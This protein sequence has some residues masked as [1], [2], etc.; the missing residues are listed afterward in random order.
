M[1][2]VLSWS[3]FPEVLSLPLAALFW[4][5]T[6][7]GL[8]GRCVS[9]WAELAEKDDWILGHFTLGRGPQEK[10]DTNLVSK[11]WT[12]QNHCLLVSAR[13]LQWKKIGRIQSVLLYV[14][15][16]SQFML[17]LSWG[18]FH[19]ISTCY[20]ADRAALA[21]QCSIYQMVDIC[22]IKSTFL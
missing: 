17:F 3:E 11:D 20:L 8:T 1:G 16:F 5:R 15:S 19:L 21:L 14:F 9:R 12:S 13:T 22:L 7:F 10:E 2:T 18:L 4:F 6:T